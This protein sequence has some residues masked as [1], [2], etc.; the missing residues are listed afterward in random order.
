MARYADKEL[1]DAQ[2]D[3]AGWF[4]SGDLGFVQDGVL[5]MTGRLKDII[6]RG[7]GNSRHRTSKMR[8]PATARLVPS[9]I[10]RSGRAPD[11]LGEAVAAAVELEP[12]HDGPG[13]KSSA[14]FLSDLGLAHPKIPEYWYIVD[15]LP[16]TASGKIRKE[17]LRAELGTTTPS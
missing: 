4:Y 9:P 3:V 12:G 13:S 6:N 2:V 15:T 11:Q 5:T 8:S 14:A 17:I 1:T 16:R 7:R 10:I